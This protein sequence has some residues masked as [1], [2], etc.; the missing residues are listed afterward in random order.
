MVNEELQ[1]YKCF[2]CNESGDIFSFVEKIEGVDFKGALELLSEKYSIPL[3]NNYSKKNQE[4]ESL[5]KRI[6]EINR[7][8]M[9]YYAF[10]LHQHQLGQSA[11]KYLTQK[12]KL[13]KEILELL[14]I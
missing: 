2:G 4:H 8:A 11:L 14:K 10:I 7:L 9:E 3:T 6:L 12:R 13:S 5:Q 1:I